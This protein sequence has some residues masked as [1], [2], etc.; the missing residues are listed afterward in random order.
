MHTCKLGFANIYDNIFLSEVLTSGQHNCSMPWD[1][2]GRILIIF[3]WELMSITQQHLLS[4]TCQITSTFHLLIVLLFINLLII[5]SRFLKNTFS[6]HYACPLSFLRSRIEY[7]CV[8][9]IPVNLAC[10]YFFSD[11]L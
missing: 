8:N 11:R 3:Q 4:R 7:S 5:S 9:Q 2:L 6:F 1:G 10:C